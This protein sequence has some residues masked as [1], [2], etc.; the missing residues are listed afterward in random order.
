[1]S[2]VALGQQA[3]FFK[4]GLS[5]SLDSVVSVFERLVQDLN[6][7]V[8]VCFLSSDVTRVRAKETCCSAVSSSRET[9]VP[10]EGLAQF[11][12]VFPRG[13]FFKS[14][15]GNLNSPCSLDSPI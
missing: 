15:D 3:G 13:A 9:G 11:S 6:L 2:L 5:Q 12:I 10:L 14:A 1:M 8:F 4:M 7:G